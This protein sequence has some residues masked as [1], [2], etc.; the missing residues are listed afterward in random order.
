MLLNFFLLLDC[1][2][3][4]LV[5]LV[6]SWL[7]LLLLDFYFVNVQL[8]FCCCSGSLIFFDS[9]YCIVWFS[10]VLFDSSSCVVWFILLFLTPPKYVFK[11]CYLQKIILEKLIFVNNNC[12][13]ASRVDCELLF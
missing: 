4:F 11:T 12:L 10:M 7:F 5:P 13:N 8:L 1:W 2:L 9:C 6:A 3:F